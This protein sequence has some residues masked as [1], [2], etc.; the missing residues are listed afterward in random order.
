VSGLDFSGPR[1]VFCGGRVAGYVV[2]VGFLGFVGED[3][4]FEE[5]VEIVG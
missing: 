1:V 3:A 4:F 5:F 2:W